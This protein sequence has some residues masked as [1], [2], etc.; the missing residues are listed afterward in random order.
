MMKK[1]MACMMAF[2]LICGILTGCSGEEG[3]TAENV[4]S[5]EAEGTSYADEEYVFITPSAS[6]EYY[7][8][9][10]KAIQDACKDLGV[11]AVLVG[12]DKAE[13]ATMVSLIEATIS[14]G[15][16][17]IVLQ[18]HFPDAYTPVIDK[19]WEAGIP[20]IVLENDAPDSKRISY[21]GNDYKVLGEKQMDAMAEVLGG[22]GKVIVSTNR[23][24]GGQSAIDQMNGVID[25]AAEKYPNIEIVA[26]VED[27]GQTDTAVQAIGAALQANPDANGVIGCQSVSGVA[28]ATACREA[29]MLDK[30]KIIAVDRD[31]A[32][33]EAI[34]DGDISA[35]VCG[36]QYAEVYY[37]TKF[38]F[39]FNH[40]DLKTS[41][42]DKAA[43]IVSVPQRVDVGTIV[44][45]K[46]N[47]EHFLG[48]TY[49]Y[50][51]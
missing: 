37:A 41:N 33:L 51:R 50:E 38:L 48:Y 15:V 23:E 30:V 26:V 11:K 45:S 22:T 1:L 34:N 46:D 13:P 12:D 21:F 28:A 35:T 9:H 4:A 32:T 25:R 6:I 27:K 2:M 42:D 31:T 17:G 39:D 3:T 7:N 43:N 47:V 24:T 16:K 40:T 19:A 10:K 8:A 29:G 14:R 44:I 18:N 49:E 20:V 36:K 5:E